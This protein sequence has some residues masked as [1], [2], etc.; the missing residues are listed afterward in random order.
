MPD[1]V[2]ITIMNPMFKVSYGYK[3]CERS[4]QDQ[5][6]DYN[7][8]KY[9]SIVSASSKHNRVLKFDVNKLTKSFRVPKQL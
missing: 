2:S 6:K 1:N 5:L 9:G 4:G 3:Q 7:W 8:S